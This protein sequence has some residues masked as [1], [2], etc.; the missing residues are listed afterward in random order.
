MGLT[1]RAPQAE[2]HPRKGLEYAA[3]YRRTRIRGVVAGDGAP[4][5]SHAEPDDEDAVVHDEL[6]V[7]V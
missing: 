2:P 6:C 3:W 5:C 1:N 7:Y 4:R